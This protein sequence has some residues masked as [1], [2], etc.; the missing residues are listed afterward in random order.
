MDTIEVKDDMIIYSYKNGLKTSWCIDV[1]ALVYNKPNIVEL[2]K[3]VCQKSDSPS[4][5][6]MTIGYE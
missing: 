3:R 5:F 1:A 4:S 2:K 6:L